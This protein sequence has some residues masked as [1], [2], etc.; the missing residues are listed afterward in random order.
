MNSTPTLNSD[1][2]NFYILGE[3]AGAAGLNYQKYNE[4]ITDLIPYSPYNYWV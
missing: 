3:P 4:K 1:F 2:Q